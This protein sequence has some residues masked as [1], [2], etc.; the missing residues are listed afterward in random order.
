MG[1]IIESIS[2]WII[3]LFEPSVCETCEYLKLQLEKEKAERNKL[4]EL[5]I[6]KQPDTIESDAVEREPISKFV[7]W[8]LRRQ[9]IE[10][11]D[12][13]E[14]RKRRLENQIKIESNKST[15]ELEREL[16]ES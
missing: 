14:S 8:H 12:R 13:E 9:M 6:P 4:I 15:D 11:K 2:Q 3:R 16:L 7:P 5:L 10:Q 1:I